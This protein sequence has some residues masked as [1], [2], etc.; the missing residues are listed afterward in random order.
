MKQ[1]NR[2]YKNKKGG[3]FVNRLNSLWQGKT[4]KTYCCNSKTSTS[5][6][7]LES[8]SNIGKDCIPSYTGQCLP[9]YGTGNNYKFR[10]FGENAD[11]AEAHTK[12]D[13]RINTPDNKCEYISGAVSKVG[14]TAAAATVGIGKFVAKASTNVLPY[15][16]A[17]LTAPAIFFKAGK[18]RK[19]RSTR[20]SKKNKKQHRK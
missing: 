17:M 6:N 9:G 12:I 18:K 11:K 5:N 7:I 14:K 10:C 4:A 1:K 15:A 8:G 19:S 16:F 20:K 3:V 2:T 13:E